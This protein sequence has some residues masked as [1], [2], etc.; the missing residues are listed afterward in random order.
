MT[1]KLAISLPDELVA[2]ARQAVS[3]GRATSV[4]AYIADS[5]T[6][7]IRHDQLTEFLA[8]MAAEAGPPG[9]ADRQWARS[10]LGLD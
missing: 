4:S 3:D 7:R 10:A 9:D 5:V 2:A 6:D 1:M 8:D